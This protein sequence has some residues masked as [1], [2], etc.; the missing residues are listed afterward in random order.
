M[1]CRC[2]ITTLTLHHKGFFFILKGYTHRKRLASCTEEFCKLQQC[3]LDTCNGR[4]EDC[5]EFKD[6][7]VLCYQCSQ[8]LKKL[9]IKEKE[10]AQLKEQ[11]ASLL[12]K[13]VHDVENDAGSSYKRTLPPESQTP[14]PKRTNCKPKRITDP[15]KVAVCN[16]FVSF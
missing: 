15:S 7:A 6:D 14:R 9:V 16:S 8:I 5:D 1:Y 12:Q 13:F 10:V 11:I 4:I 2:T 3:F